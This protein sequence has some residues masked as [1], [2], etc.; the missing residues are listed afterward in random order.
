VH[1]LLQAYS[2]MSFMLLVSSMLA[3][4]SLRIVTGSTSDQIKL[5]REF[6]SSAETTSRNCI[7]ARH[8]AA[9]W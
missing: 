9:T 4:L 2:Q 5:L 8:A 3:I 1:E 6:R 7:H